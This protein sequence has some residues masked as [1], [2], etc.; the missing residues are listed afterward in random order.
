LKDRI[1]QSRVNGTIQAGNLSYRGY[2]GS[3]ILLNTISLKALGDKVQVESAKL[4]WKDT[5]VAVRGNVGKDPGGLLVD[6]TVESEGFTWEKVPRIVEREKKKKTD[7]PGGQKGGIFGAVPVHGTI[8]VNAAYFQYGELR[9]EPFA[10]DLNLE[11]KR[12]EVKITNGRLCGIPTEATVK[13]SPEPVELKAEAGAES[14][15][16]SQT[17][18]FLDARLATG[19]FDFIGDI[20]AWGASED[21]IRNLHGQ[22]TITAENGRIYRFGLL[23]KI[24]SVVNITE[25]FKGR[26]PDVTGEGL[27]YKSAKFT[28]KIEQ[29]RL[30]L[31]EGYIDGHSM[32]LAFKGGIDLSARKLDATVLVTVLKTVDTI[33]ENIPILGGILG[34][35]FIAIPVQVRG[36][37]NDPSV[38][39]LPPSA[40]GSGLLGIL[41]RTLKLPGKLIQ[42]L[43]PG[44]K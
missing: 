31:E 20:A 23:S 7:E 41:E 26:A 28:G 24:L 34:E 14:G 33:L 15:E 4:A 8:D 36:D 35:N 19:Q 22:F 17:P 11:G 2:M 42:P 44:K 13:G 9:W 30:E 29:G 39:P 5:E 37:I 18:C 21:L 10:F 38:V 1:D 3:P 25:I 27:G 12:V 40:V 6:L 32:G 16:L 43:I